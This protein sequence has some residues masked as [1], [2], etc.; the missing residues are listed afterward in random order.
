MPKKVKIELDFD[1]NDDVV[2]ITN[3]SEPVHGKV[4]EI[5]LSD[6]EVQYLVAS[7]VDEKFCYAIEL[8]SSEQSQK[9]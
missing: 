7:G 6:K 5:K 3:P 1:I 4:T 2:V 8:Q 9:K